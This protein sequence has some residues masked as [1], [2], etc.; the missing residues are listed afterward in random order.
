MTSILRWSA[1]HRSLPRSS[2]SPQ[3]H[4]QGDGFGWLLLF[5]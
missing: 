2:L 1:Q 4:L 5:L 3:Q